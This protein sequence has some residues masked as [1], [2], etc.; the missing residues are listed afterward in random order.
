MLSNDVRK[1]GGLCSLGLLLAACSGGAA[2][3]TQNAAPATGPSVAQKAAAAASST[4]AAGGAPA[5]PVAAVPM[6]LNISFKSDPDPVRTGP[7]NL[8][9]KVLGADGKPVTDA[10]V[11]A[12]FFMPAMPSMNMPA[13]R[14]TVP[15]QSAGNGVYR[16]TGQL[17]M[18]GTWD[19]T[20]NVSR[21]GE[22]LGSKKLTVIGK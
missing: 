6:P 18:G 10:T 19:V 2:G 7:N 13:M 8:E 3:A 14:N 16:G 12:A 17:E 15:L 21:N 20:V 1:T 9:V 4:A 5:S 22:K 11:S